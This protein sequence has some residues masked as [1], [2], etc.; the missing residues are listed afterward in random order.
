M[1]SDPAGQVADGQDSL[2]TWVGGGV[3]RVAAPL[4]EQVLDIVRQAIMSFKLRPGSRLIERELVEQLGVSRTTV[5]DVLARLAAEGLVTI[6]PQRGAI[7]SV[8]TL[9]EAADIYDMRAALEALAVRRFVGRASPQEVTQLRA[10]LED[11]ER[12]AEENDSAE[13]LRAK[14]SFYEVLLT[15]A[16][17]PR[18]TTILT[19]LQG[20]VRLLRATSLSVTDRPKE[21]AAEI[22]A[23]VEAIEAGN[24]DAGAKACTRHVRNAA[25]VGLG[26]LSR[27][28]ETEDELDV[29]APRRKY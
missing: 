17:S 29:L 16:R 20:Q 13:A 23:V 7:V 2:S 14:D 3:G 27:L 19:S 15:G 28:Q 4:R 12:A 26:R 21:A 9:E 24:A 8:L 11:I 10:T 25:K 6:I 22:R 1:A 18:L 5:R